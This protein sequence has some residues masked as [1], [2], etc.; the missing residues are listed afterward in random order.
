MIE[1]TQQ[2]ILITMYVHIYIYIYTYAYIHIHTYIYIYIHILGML[3]GETSIT[4]V[5]GNSNSKSNSNSNS[6]SSHEGTCFTIP[7]PGRLS[8]PLCG[9]GTSDLGP[10]MYVC[11]YIYIYIYIYMHIVCMYVCIYIYTYICMCVY[12]CMSTCMCMC[13]HIY[14]YIYIYIYMYMGGFQGVWL[15][16]NLNLKGWNS[17]VHR[18]FTGKLDSSNVSRDNVSRGIRRMR[19]Y[20]CQCH[21]VL[22][23]GLRVAV[24]ALRTTLNTTTTRVPSFSVPGAET[25]QKFLSSGPEGYMFSNNC[26]KCNDNPLRETS[27]VVFSRG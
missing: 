17:Q 21:C 12:V 23:S 19:A 6:N 10:N 1:L 24:Q 3:R 15:Q 20:R 18:G 11:I 5:Y 8:T 13:I 4:S 14:I 25:H 9:V 26:S 22:V 2:H 27:E 16:H 7:L